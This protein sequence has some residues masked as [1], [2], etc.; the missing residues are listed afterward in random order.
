MKNLLIKL[1]QRSDLALAFLLVAIIFMMILPLPTGLVDGLIAL[2]L[3]IAVI[4]LMLSVYILSPLE[5]TA[6]P[7]VLLITT[8][9]RL[10]LSITTTRLILMDGDAGSII[11][12]FG[13]FVVGGNLVVGTVIFLIITIV[14][15]MVITKGAERVAEVS[16]RFSLDA[17]PGKQMSIDGDMR[18]GVLDIDDARSKRNALNRE[19]QLFGS[20]DGAM[21]FVKGDAIAGLIII[22]VNILGG[23]TIGMMQRGMS[24]GE[25]LEVYSILTIGDGL[26]SQIPALFISI[27]AGIIVTRVSSGDE[28]EDQANLGKDIG[29]QLTAQPKALVIGAGL[30]V[31]FALIPGFPTL[32]FLGFAA[33]IGGGGYWLSRAAGNQQEEP[34]SLPEVLSNGS[35]AAATSTPESKKAAAKN[36][37]SGA[38][39]FSITVPLLVD[40]SANLE[41]SLNSAN[42]NAE[43]SQVR[44]ALYLDMGVPFP[45]V[46][47]R[48]NASLPANEYA[49]LMQEIPVARGK[50]K[51]G[52]LMVTET[53]Q[54]LD[55]LGIAY[56]TEEKFLPGFA[57]FW[58]SAERREDLTAGS[59]SYFDLDKVI[60][61][62]LSHVLR[63]YAEDFI[64]I[65]ESRFLLE[66]IEPHYGEL[67]KEVQRVVPIQK[68]SEVMQRLVSEDISI[69]NLRVIL[70]SLVEWGQKEKDVVQLTEYIRSSQKRY[71]C[72]K[73][74][75]GQNVLP[76]YLLDQGIEEQIR[77]SI[78]QTSAGCYL[79]LDP[80][81]TQKFVANTV[82]SIGDLKKHQRKPVL[83]VAMDIRR[84]VR[85][86]IENELYELPVLSFQELTK[87]INVQPIGRINV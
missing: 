26:I 24:A 49:I 65:Q 40:V 42:L 66:K 75:A 72:Y 11:T 22:F 19:S 13:N 48:F 64:G 73:Y 58:V 5:F 59:L 82:K 3:S 68:I 46:H 10:A 69:R 77:S 62:H 37:A 85:K 35:G 39:E 71:I 50:L 38:E 6:F 76:A 86:L 21:K 4:L 61:F 84:Y 15:F 43:L 80:G 63:K 2:N 70:E 67:V 23:I 81:V 53:Q 12:T 27:T 57:S 34:E 17:M 45:G 74:A 32:I 14:Q 31:G 33:L 30:L 9:F 36:R 20:M 55:M 52:H 8:L 79:A 18:A 25:A 41:A 87:E 1:S 28:D 29:A 44:R 54:Q 47:L 83:L 51:E 7:A 78:R 60:T 16:A 56:Q